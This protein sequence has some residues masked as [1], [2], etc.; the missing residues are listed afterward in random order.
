MPQLIPQASSPLSTQMQIVKCLVRSRLDRPT[1]EVATRLRP[2]SVSTLVTLI[3]STIR[4][5]ILF[6]NF[7]ILL[8]KKTFFAL[9]FSAIQRINFKAFLWGHIYKI[10]LFS[11]RLWDWERTVACWGKRNIDG[12]VSNSDFVFYKFDYFKPIWYDFE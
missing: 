1:I 3:I 7:V 2:A 10:N 9:C 5:E 12:E 11:F 8:L 6:F 4:I